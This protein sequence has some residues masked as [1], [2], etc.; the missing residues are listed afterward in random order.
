MWCLPQVSS[1]VPVFGFCCFLYT[2]LNVDII[3]YN[4]G[5]VIWWRKTITC[6]FLFAYQ[7]NIW[8]FWVRAINYYPFRLLIGFV[9]GFVKIAASRSGRSQQNKT[10]TTH[11]WWC[12][13][14]QAYSI[15][16]GWL[17]WW[18]PGTDTE[19]GCLRRRSG[20]SGRKRRI[21][22]ISCLG[23]FDVPR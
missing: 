18:H 19:A 1:I 22:R 20:S 10:T 2:A 7:K 13:D 9:F 5:N 8:A 6:C 16:C 4:A 21:N 17:P 14:V 3:S 12:T 15:V 23:S 11:C